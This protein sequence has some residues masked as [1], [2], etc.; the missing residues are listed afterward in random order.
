MCARPPTVTVDTSWNPEIAELVGAFREA[1]NTT[2]LAETSEGD[3]VIYKPQAGQRPLWDFDATS[4][5]AREWLTY[6]VSRSLG[7]EIVPETTLGE[8]P[9]GPGSIQRYVEPG[10]SVDLVALVNT[11]D[12]SL[13]PVAVLDLVTNNADRKLGHLLPGPA[14]GFWAIDHGLT[15][16]PEEKLRTV[17]WAFAGRA[18]PE[19]LRAGLAALRSDLTG[20]L[21][22]RL[23][24]HLGAEAQSA[25]VERVDDLI[26]DGRHP[27]PPEDRPALPWPVV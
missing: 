16:H 11:A 19:P 10:R 20:R 7:F 1:S 12:P 6:L 2:L 25:V 22:E 3:R 24:A 5:P 9:L 4:L 17:L 18:I 13:W 21:G 23:S 14:G 8:G 27:Q 26:A 15:F